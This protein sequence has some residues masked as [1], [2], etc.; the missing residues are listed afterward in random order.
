VAQKLGQLS[1]GDLCPVSFGLLG[2]KDYF[3]G[4]AYAGLLVAAAASSG[5]GARRQLLRRQSK[6][7]CHTLFAVDPPVVLMHFGKAAFK[8]SLTSR[9]P[10]T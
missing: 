4:G 2:S 9:F 10:M 5:A 8:T 1:E 3:G 6:W 7:E